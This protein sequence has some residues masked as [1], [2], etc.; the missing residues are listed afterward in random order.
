MS[1]RIHQC[2]SR[3]VGN[4]AI[5]RSIAETQLSIVEGQK[6]REN[7]TGTSHRTTN[8]G[9]RYIF[10]FRYVYIKAYLN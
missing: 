4:D 9:E 10:T 3:D 7:K 6:K 2:C 1:C 5:I 8:V